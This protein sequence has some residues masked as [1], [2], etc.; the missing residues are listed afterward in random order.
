MEAF[1]KKPKAWMWAVPL[2]CFQT[3]FSI[4]AY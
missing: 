3:T 1:A 4:A 2:W